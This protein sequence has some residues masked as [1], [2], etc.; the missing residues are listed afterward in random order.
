MHDFVS[1]LSSVA[2]LSQHL[3]YIACECFFFFFKKTYIDILVIFFDSV[4]QC[5]TGS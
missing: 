2:H 1:M 5:C 4:Q 3:V